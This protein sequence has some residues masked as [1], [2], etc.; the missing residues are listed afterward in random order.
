MRGII[1]T[2]EHGKDRRLDPL[3]GCVEVIGELHIENRVMQSRVV[4]DYLEV[5]Q[6]D[7]PRKLD[8]IKHSMRRELAEFLVR[9]AFED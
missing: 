1:K 8:A 3:A 2:V 9:E 6:P 5:A 4:V 7:W